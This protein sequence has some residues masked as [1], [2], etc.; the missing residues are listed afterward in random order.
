MMLRRNTSTNNHTI[1]QI[2]RHCGD[3]K[4]EKS[5]HKHI[6]IHMMKKKYHQVISSSTAPR[7]LSS[8]A[9]RSKLV[10]N[11]SISFGFAY[12]FL[13]LV[14]SNGKES[15]TLRKNFPRCTM[16]SSEKCIMNY[17]TPLLPFFYVE[18]HKSKLRD[19]TD[20]LEVGDCKAMGQWQ[21]QSYPNCNLLHEISEKSN[22]YR[23]TKLLANGAYRDTWL[24][25]WNGVPYAMKTLVSTDEM[26]ARNLD[27]HRRDAIA[28][29]MLSSSIHIPNIYAHCKK[30]PTFV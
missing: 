7:W 17:N 28:M 5:Q 1:K 19:N 18:N 14:N 8:I 27:R 30:V 23:D 10:L 16:L 2:N 11:L 25:H 20:E 29:S 3:D 15:K 6:H 24:I 9:L 4:N 22:N 21:L 13:M 26:S 12:L